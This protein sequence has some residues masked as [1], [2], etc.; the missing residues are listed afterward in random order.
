MTARILLIEDN[1]A[2]ME[3]MA[4]LLG[5]S[6]HVALYA[7]NE[8]EALASASREQPD[9]VICDVNLPHLDGYAIARRLRDDPAM[10]S[11]PAIA[12][13]A[14]S[15]A[16]DGEEFLDAGFNGCISKPLDPET[17]VGSIE[18]FLRGDD[19]SGR[20]IK[21]KNRLQQGR[22]QDGNDPDR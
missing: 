15:I 22:S 14:P 6:G 8:E 16:G 12:I 17:F 10:R 4:Y 13:T 20:P 3:L 1:P 19:M 7:H 21:I 11:I 9:L 2:D 5:S 18:T